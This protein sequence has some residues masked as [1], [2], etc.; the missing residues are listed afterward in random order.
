M[1]LNICFSCSVICHM[2]PRIHNMTWNTKLGLVQCNENRKAN[3]PPL[4]LTM[5]FSARNIY[6]LSLSK[7]Q[8]VHAITHFR[9]AV[10]FKDNVIP[11]SQDGF[12]KNGSQ[13]VVIISFCPK[14]TTFWCTEFVRYHSSCLSVTQNIIHLRARKIIKHT[15]RQKLKLQTSEA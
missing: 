1:E 9:N 7:E 4:W 15:E 2:A 5:G 13:T 11:V 6:V 14:M 8:R 12:K 10:F 3:S